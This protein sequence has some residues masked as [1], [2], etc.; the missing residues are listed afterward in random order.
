MIKVNGIQLDFDITSPADVTR[1]KQAGEKMEAE[2][3]K[4]Q[5][6][7]LEPDNPA[8]LDA[9]IDMLNAE[10]RLFG[11]FLDDVFGDGVAARLLGGNPSLSKVAQINE[12]LGLAMEEQG[13][14]FGVRIQ[15]YTPN[16]AAR[17]AK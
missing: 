8:F 2:G 9:Y 10:L 6:P 11:N 16:R 12:A 5:L 3:A 15:K 14:A 7:A 17:R 13:K 1:Y 4:I